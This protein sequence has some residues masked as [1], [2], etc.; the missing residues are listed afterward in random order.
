[1]PNG[2][3]DVCVASNKGYDRG[4]SKYSQAEPEPTVLAHENFVD[5]KVSG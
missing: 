4:P 2:G 5:Y 3:N 1:V